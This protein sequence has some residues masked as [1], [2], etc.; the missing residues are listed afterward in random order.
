MTFSPAPITGTVT[1]TKDQFSEVLGLAVQLDGKTVGRV[2]K[3]E[4]ARDGWFYTISMFGVYGSG[5][6]RTRAAAIET[7]ARRAQ[8][9]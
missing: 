3:S 9:G 4:R 7:V 1:T 8:R 6:A 2:K 5:H